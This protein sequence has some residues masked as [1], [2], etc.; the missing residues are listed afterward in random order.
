MIL[1]GELALWVALLM[2]AWGATASFAGRYA[3]RGELMASGQR[4]LYATFGCLVLA[5]SGLLIALVRSD[6]SLEYVASV[7]SANLPVAYRL[8][9]LWGG[10][11]GS[12]LLWGVILSMYGAIV[13]ASSGARARGILPYAAGAISAI[14]L[15]L[16]LIVCVVANPYERVAITPPDGAGMHPR[17]QN[18]GMALHPPILSLGYVATAI[19]FALTIAAL[20][21]RAADDDWL[22][23]VRRW[24]LASWFF[25]T[26]G[27]TIGMWWA[28]TEVGWGGLWAWDPVQ[29]ASLL[30]WITNTALLHA[31]SVQDERGLFRKSVA[32]LALSGF[33]LVLL[34]AFI[35][36]SGVIPSIHAASPS[37]AGSWFGGLLLILVAASALVLTRRLEEAPDSARPPSVVSRDGTVVPAGIVVLV[38]IASW[39]LL[40][41]LVPLLNEDVNGGQPV[42]PA[43]FWALVIPLGLVLL[44]LVG[45]GSLVGWG[46]ASV[47]GV[48]RRALVPT[49]V[50]AAVVLLLAALGMREVVALVT[51]GASA[52]AL[53]AVGRAL[54]D[55][56]ASRRFTRR[57]GDVAAPGR[58][59]GGLV[60]HAGV[61]ALFAAF[62]GSSLRV[63]HEVSL[64]PGEAATLRDP[65]GRSWTFTSQGVSTF[66]ERDRRVVAVALQMTRD[67]QPMGLVRGERRQYLD[68]R[69]MPVFEPTPE[70]GIDY[71]LSQD[72]Y[73]VLRSETGERAHLRIAFHP[74]VSW[75]WIAALMTAL[76]G[77]LVMWPTRQ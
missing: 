68:S 50:A 53:G 26:V 13:V 29:S 33:L 72:V 59:R 18:P 28:H 55:D 76:G 69:G 30:P 41:L 54:V 35:T 17:L 60:V 43:F 66:E 15:V 1:V 16:V 61:A 64:S 51:F 47:A 44:V 2:A 70:P 21:G 24:A 36:R 9:A 40:G 11:G 23:Q 8:S 20:M 12:L 31:M 3:G 48:R 14:T 74:L 65:F 22:P 57:D 32:I 73:V 6:F 39:I 4:A 37:E 46:Y 49:A 42:G 25:L 75:V 5:T 52:F 10:E 71:S 19:P 34:G 63:E 77:V 45:V 38:A 58:R 56:S 7:T 27:I 62:A 67:G